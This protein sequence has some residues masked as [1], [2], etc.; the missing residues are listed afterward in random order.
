M[1]VSTFKLARWKF[2]LAIPKDK[3]PR[4]SINLLTAVTFR[5][6]KP[7]NVSGTI[8]PIVVFPAR[9]SVELKLE[10]TAEGFPCKSESEADRILQAIQA[11]NRKVPS[12]GLASWPGHFTLATISNPDYFRE[13]LVLFRFHKPKVVENFQCGYALRIYRH[14]VDKPREITWEE[15]LRTASARVAKRA[16]AKKQA[17]LVR[18]QAARE[19]KLNGPAAQ[20]DADLTAIQLK[21]LSKAYPKTVAYLSN[22]NSKDAEAAFVAYKQETLAATGHLIDSLTKG[23][24]KIVAK[25]LEKASRRKNPSLNEIEFQLV[26]GWRLH[27]YAKMTPEQRFHKL[28]EL[29]FTPA[30]PD[31]VRKMCERLKLPSMRKRGAPHKGFSSK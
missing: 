2:D 14:F 15:I 24:F 30:S 9:L 19:N 7:I 4:E 20:S 27:G 13:E 31:A 8:C 11:K 21:V 26:A 23:E 17:E 29:G 25:L 12:V 6:D 22:P 16:L 1:I 10:Q 5:P 3:I 28:K 18:Q